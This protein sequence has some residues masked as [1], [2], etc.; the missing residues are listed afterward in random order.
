MASGKTGVT[1]RLTTASNRP[2]VS[3]DQV[4]AEKA[5]I[6]VSEIFATQGEAAFRS[7]ESEA[8]AGLDPERPLVLDTGGGLVQVPDAMATLRA[9]GVVIW[10]DAPWEILRRRLKDSD[11]A[12][13]PLIARLGWSGLEEL[14]RRRRRLYAAAADFRLRSDQGTIEELAQKA[15]LR[16]LQWERQGG[17]VRR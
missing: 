12:S 14:F 4:I 13:R 8:L 6:S 2:A 7:L 16:S 15:M 3:L 11:Q 10:L 17:E 9:R 5:G 1:R